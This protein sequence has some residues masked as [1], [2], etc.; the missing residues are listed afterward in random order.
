[1][2]ADQAIFFVGASFRGASRKPC[3]SNTGDAFVVGICTGPF[4]TAAPASNSLHGP[5]ITADYVVNSHPDARPAA[6][7]LL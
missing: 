1:M 5:S 2:R 7:Q 3:P 6:L 4:S